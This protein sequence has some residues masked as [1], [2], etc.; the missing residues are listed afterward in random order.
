[1]TTDIKK[2]SRIGSVGTA[3][4]ARSIAITALV[5]GARVA[6]MMLSAS[7]SC[8]SCAVAYFAKLGFHVEV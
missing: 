1:L 2:F 7:P 4:L 6:A 5:G 3:I 8:R